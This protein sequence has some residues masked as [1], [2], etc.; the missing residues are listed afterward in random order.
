[1]NLVQLNYVKVVAE[2]GSFSAA[3]RV[4]GVAQPT[5]SNAV[6]DL[7]TELGAKLFKRTTRRVELS[8]FGRHILSSLEGVL[9]SVGD[10]ERQAA[11]FLNPQRRLLRVAFSP[12]IDSKRLMALFEPFKQGRP[13]L[14]IIYKECSVED[15]EARLEGEKADVICGIRLR[16]G[17]G[18][19]RCVL[20]QD[21]LRYL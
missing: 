19:G 13:E 18:R 6:S 15:L 2:T 8:A 10:L 7:E 11:T 4:C 20:Y 3:A 1:M 12:I 17:A 5:V 16:D 14:E 21:I 9:T